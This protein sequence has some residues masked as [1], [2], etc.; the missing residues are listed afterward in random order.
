MLR[1]KNISLS[2]IKDFMSSLLDKGFKEKDTNK[3]KIT[4]YD[5]TKKEFHIRLSTKLNELLDYDCRVYNHIM[6][7]FESRKF[8]DDDDKC[9]RFDISLFFGYKT[10]HRIHNFMYTNKYN[11]S[12]RMKVFNFNDIVT[13][14]NNAIKYKNKIIK[15]EDLKEKKINE[16][17]QR[18]DDIIFNGDL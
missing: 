3:T 13:Y 10:F 1:V 18:Q 16:L 5:L 8:K 11:E 2:N 15:L 4:D 17:N 6:V 14:V 7:D 9:E 12:E